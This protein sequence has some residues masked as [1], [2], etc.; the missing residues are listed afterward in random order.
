MNSAH[1]GRLEA[2]AD[3]KWG[4]VCMNGWTHENGVVACRELGF[5][6]GLK[7]SLRGHNN[8][9]PGNGIISYNSLGCQG[10]EN[11]LS[12]CANNFG[13]TCLFYQDIGI[14]CNKSRLR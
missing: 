6:P 5:P 2:F 10:N 3:S 9:I 8:V 12:K 14:V 13:E 4:T 11:Q 7:S 1:V